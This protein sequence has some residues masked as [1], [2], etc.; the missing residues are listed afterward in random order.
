[1]AGH[2]LGEYAALYAAGAISFSDVLPLVKARAQYHQQAVPVGMGAMAAIIGLGSEVVEDLCRDVDEEDG[3]VSLAIVNAPGQIVVSGCT[4]DVERVM[5]LAK[6]KGA[7]RAVKLPISVPCHCGM[8]AETSRLL[9]AYLEKIAIRDF[10]TPVIPNCDPEV[11]YTRESAKELLARLVV[12]PVRWQGTVEKMA[13]LGV[14]TIVEIGPKRVL[15]GLIKRIDKS[16]RLCNVE[17]L[18]SLNN[19]VAQLKE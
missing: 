16:I 3:I 6:D 1:M 7:A 4:G 13:A 11:F 15:S 19:T 10:E 18:E 9:R 12:S 2:S 14:D 8:L 17:D 5:A